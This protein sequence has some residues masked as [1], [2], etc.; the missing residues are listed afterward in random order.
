[1]ITVRIN[2]W[3]IFIICV[4]A[5]HNIWCNES[6]I[7]IKD[8]TL[9]NDREHSYGSPSTPEIKTTDEEYQMRLSLLAKNIDNSDFLY[10][11][12]YLALLKGDLDNSEEYF[13]LSLKHDNYTIPYYKTYIFYW[14]GEINEKRGNLF[15]A[16]DYLIKHGD[17][18]YIHLVMAKIYRT[19][20]L[21]YLAE[22]EY[23]SAQQQ[24]LFEECNYEP[25][26]L[27]ID[28]FLEIKDYKKAQYYV[29]SYIRTLKSFEEDYSCDIY[30]IGFQEEI[31]KAEELLN[32][33]DKITNK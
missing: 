8:S 29:K 3:P 33:L 1:M 11:L 32:K 22:S 12:A 17:T 30:E 23:I 25:F 7:T 21:Y 4:F 19:N 28:M 18:Y 10:E 26:E 14:L 20:K 15:K 31:Q 13:N 9:N 2:L 24:P 6:N 27:I 5:C 16:L